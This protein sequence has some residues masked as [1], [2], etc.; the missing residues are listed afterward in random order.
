MRYLLALLFLPSLAFGQQ[1]ANCENTPAVV[2][3][4]YPG[5]PV[6][7]GT[8]DQPWQAFGKYNANWLVVAPVFNSASGTIL[9]N[10]SGNMGAMSA[11]ST[12]PF[13]LTVPGGGT[14]A[15]SLSGPI[16]GNGTS[17]MTPAAAADIYALWS[18]TCSS[19]TFLRGDGSCAAPSGSGTVTT[20]GSPAS[21]NL[22]KFSGG[23]VITNGDLSGDCTTSGTLA[24]TCTQTNGTAFGTFATQSYASPPAIGGTTPAAGSFTTLAASSTVSGIGFSTYLASPPAIGSVSP[25]TGKFTTINGYT[26][27]AGTATLNFGGNFTSAGAVTYSGGFGG[28]F[29]LTGTTA[30]TFP[31]SGTLVN[32]GVTS[33]SSLATVGTIGTGTWQGTAVGAGYGG[34]GLTSGI[35]GGILGFTGTTTIASSAL[36]AANALIVGGGAGATPSSL[37]GTGI[38]TLSSGTVTVNTYVPAANG[39]CGVNVNPTATTNTVCG[40][41]PGAVTGARDT[42]YGYAT[43]GNAFSTGTDDTLIGSQAG[44]YLT[45]GS[46]NTA[47]GSTALYGNAGVALTGSSNSA[48]GNGALANCQGACANN[49]GLGTNAGTNI[50]TG[51]SNVVIGAAGQTTITTGTNNILIGTTTATD[52]VAAGT[53]HEI[54]IE[55]VLVEYATAPTVTS[56]GGTSP[57][58]DAKGTQ[59]F[60]IIEGATG[61]PSAT[62]VLGMPTSPLNDWV[63]FAQDRTSSSITAR[64]SGAASTTAVTITF[65]GAPANNDVIQFMCGASQ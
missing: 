38:P 29:T 8:G 50:T 5:G 45:I 65:S 26:L 27:T 19:T 49:T 4:T 22:A 21:G 9:G 11:L 30:V 31:T 40:N 23:T 10:A 51:T 54:N 13:T 47:V 39:G 16:K 44:L 56:G 1:L 6:N 42:F 43:G 14:G 55:N 32:S 37:T 52:T 61:T 36:L 20:S 53:T 33:L 57:T 15:I 25:G 48:F 17:A 60:R 35:S 34:T 12:L 46:F 62:L 41:S 7:T 2:A 64:Q 63:C 58:I 3:C 18:G 24:I 28:T 59:F